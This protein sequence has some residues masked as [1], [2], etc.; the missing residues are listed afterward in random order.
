MRIFKTQN[1]IS[2]Q[3]LLVAFL[4]TNVYFKLK[5]Q[6]CN[7][8]YKRT[9]YVHMERK[10]KKKKSNNFNGAITFYLN[11]QNLIQL[12]QKNVYIP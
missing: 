1:S 3:Q 6:F 2:Q 11:S 4:Q 9:H 5:T 12:A 10:K 7:S 8:L